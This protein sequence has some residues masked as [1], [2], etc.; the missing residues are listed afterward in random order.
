M[1]RAWPV[2]PATHRY[3]V[4]DGNRTSRKETIM[5]S[6]STAADMVRVA[7]LDE[8]K[9]KQ[10]IVAHPGDRPV[11]VWYHDGEVSAVD[12]RCPHLGFP[13]HKGTVTDGIL[14]C[15]WHHARFDLCSGCTFDLWAD[16]VPAYVAQVRDGEV[17]ISS[18]PRQDDQSAYYM[19]RLTD[20]MQQNISLIQAKSLIALMRSGVSHRDIVKHVALFGVDNRDGWGPGLTIL[21]AMANLVPHLS[22]ETAY[23]ALFQGTRM[24]AGDCA[25][26]APRRKRHALDTQQLTEDTL[27]RWMSYWTLVRHRDGAERTL[28]TAID[29]GNEINLLLLSAATE[30]PYANIGHVLDFTNKAFE[31]LSLIGHEHAPRVLPS[32]VAQM[33][34]ARGGEESNPWRHPV[35]LIPHLN[36]IADELPDLLAQGSGKSWDRETQLA[37]AILVDD[38]LAVIASLRQVMIDGAEPLQLS[39]AL[40]YA[41]ALRLARFGV[42][43]EFGDWDT[44]LHTFTYCNALHQSLK[45]CDAP[46]VLRGIFHGAISVYLDRFLNIPP[47]KLP[48]ERGHLDDLPTD[49]GEILT[50]LFEQLDQR[51]DIDHVAKLVARYLRQG[52]DVKALFDA[53]VRG[54]VREDGD[55]HT[56]QMIEG[57]IAQYHEWPPASAQAEHI[58]VAAARYLAAHCPTRRA[59]LQTATVALR[60]HRGDR[61]YEEDE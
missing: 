23:L 58:L 10:V 40:A 54:A 28:L 18:R 13:L 30:R 57:A 19:R 16:D 56:M 25:G 1:P 52:N 46:A 35:D 36:Q 14:T 38:P 7:S 39:K 41:A 24:T 22:D 55:F 59:Q 29:N 37:G 42:S 26:Q 6:T 9:A 49:G 61:I 45:R 60:L 33:V 47:A 53:L 50:Q 15:H 4:R 5:A 20:G 17:Y 44:A 43:N 27:Q 51:S 31:L 12:N 32:L 11:A 3:N 2:D 48:G 34:A 21:T 8:L